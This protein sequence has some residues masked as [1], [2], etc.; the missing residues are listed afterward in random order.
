MR[1]P[2]IVSR[3][4]FAGKFALLVEALTPCDGSP[5]YY[6]LGHNPGIGFV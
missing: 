4:N 5:L 3:R 2:V 1:K 6:F